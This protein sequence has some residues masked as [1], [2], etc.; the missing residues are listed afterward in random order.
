MGHLPISLPRILVVPYLQTFTP[1]IP[2]ASSKLKCY[3]S[4]RSSYHPRSISLSLSINLSAFFRVSIT[5]VNVCKYRDWKLSLRGFS[6]FWKV[7]SK[8]FFRGTMLCYTLEIWTQRGETS[9][10]CMEW[11]IFVSCLTVVRHVSFEFSHL[12]K[13]IT[14]Y[15]PSYS[16]SLSLLKKIGTTKGGNEDEWVYNFSV[17]A[18]SAFHYRRR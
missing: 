14:R 3:F 18:M 8:V 17:G 12:A 9:T 11:S 15:H 16:L 6:L 5:M 4:N 13:V 2:R 7:F 10:A 1:S